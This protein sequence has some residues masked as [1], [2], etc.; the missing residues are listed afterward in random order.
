ML[1]EQQQ[2]AEGYR[3]EAR[4]ALEHLAEFRGQGPHARIHRE[5]F[6]QMRHELGKEQDDRL[7]DVKSMLDAMRQDILVTREQQRRVQT[8]QLLVS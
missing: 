7:T 4:R 3:H 1:S 5:T 8:A 6:E 2:L